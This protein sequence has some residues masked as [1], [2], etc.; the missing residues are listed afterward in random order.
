ML[1]EQSVQS[2]YVKDYSDVVIKDWRTQEP[3]FFLDNVI[4]TETSFEGQIKESTGGQFLPTLITWNFEQENMF[5]MMINNL[6][7][8]VVSLATECPVKKEQGYIPCKEN[9]ELDES[10]TIPLKG[11]D[12]PRNVFCYLNNMDGRTIIR[13][14]IDYSIIKNEYNDY[15][16]YEDTNWILKINDPDIREGDHITLYYEWMGEHSS[17]LVE[18][19]NKV[20]YYTIE[21]FSR[22]R[23]VYGFSD[24]DMYMIITFP[25]VQVM[26]GITLQVK[27]EEQELYGVEVRSIGDGDKNRHLM[28]MRVVE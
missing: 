16:Y 3:V 25:K 14:I 5:R 27:N 12:V 17:I 7:L 22:V 21:C 8:E 9:I 23:K 4:L 15:D 10:L 2:F 18:N 13:E 24:D 1:V 19:T 20:T 28:T 6:S 11:N 26:P